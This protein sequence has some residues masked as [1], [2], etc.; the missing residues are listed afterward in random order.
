ME[1]F[2][3]GTFQISVG[4]GFNDKR[5][6]LTCTISRDGSITLHGSRIA[7]PFGYFVRVCAVGELPIVHSSPDEAAYYARFYDG[8][9]IPWLEANAV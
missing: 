8:F 9:V 2:I 4:T 7:K 5:T 1:W 3:G 6:T